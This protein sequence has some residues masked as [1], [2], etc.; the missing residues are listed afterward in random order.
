M[1]RF[2]SNLKVVPVMDGLEACKAIRSLDRP[3]AST[4]PIIALT[5]NVFFEDTKKCLDAG[6]FRC[7]YLFLRQIFSKIFMKM[8]QCLIFHL[9]SN[10]LPV[11]HNAP[12]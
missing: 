7:L 10:N 5:A 6:M 3:D 11:L 9:T 4:I 8:K 1:V 12:W 2:M